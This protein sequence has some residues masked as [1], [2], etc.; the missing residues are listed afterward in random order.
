MSDIAMILDKLGRTLVSDVAPHLEGSYAGGQAG[1]IGIM[2]TMAGE[3]WDGAADRLVREIDGARALLKAGGV[4]DDAQPQSLKIS[5][6]TAV[7]DRLVG[8]LVVLHA[9]IEAE[10]SQAARALNAQIWGF[11]LSGAL[12]RMPSPPDF[13]PSEDEAADRA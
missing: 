5:E 1:M 10:E 7:R 12:E 8:Q 13:A 6:L 11:L 3:A 4:E 9:R 2:A